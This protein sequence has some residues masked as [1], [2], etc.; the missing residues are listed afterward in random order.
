MRQSRSALAVGALLVLPVMVGFV[1]AMLGA[2][3]IVGGFGQ[4]AGTARLQRVLAEPAVWRGTAWALWV[5]VASTALA[6]FVAVVLSLVYAGT[7][8]TDRFARALMNIPLA[9]PHIVAATVALLILGQ[10]GMLERILVMAGVITSSAQMPELVADR[11]GIGV[12]V[13]LVWKETPFLLLINAAVLGG[14]GGGYPEVARTHGASRWQVLQR[15]TWPLLWRGLSPALVAVAVFSFGNYE[16]M[17]L[18]AP[19]NPLALP[20]LTAERY[21]DPALARRNDAFVLALLGIVVGLLA[22]ALHER[23]R[24]GVDATRNA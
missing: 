14:H 17:V 24:S 16:T 22:V 3:D 10:S 1:Y 5:A 19:S 13:T 7:S 15:V 4:A 18:L 9:F 6:A 2:T 21:I 11:F 8:R 23:I 20:L 12:I